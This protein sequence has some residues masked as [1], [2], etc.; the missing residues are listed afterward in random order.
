MMVIN[1]LEYYINFL[2]SCTAKLNKNRVFDNQY[3]HILYIIINPEY[4][5]LNKMS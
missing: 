1:K 3:K 5:N 2:N 4:V